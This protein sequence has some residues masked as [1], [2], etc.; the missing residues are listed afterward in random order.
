MSHSSTDETTTYK[1]VVND[2]DQYSILPARRANPAGW[3]DAGVSGPK[4]DCLEHIDRVWQ[5]MRPRSLREEME[6]DEA[7]GAPSG[8]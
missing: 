3:S 4:A 1:V 7:D 5:D 8:V 6:R 2:E